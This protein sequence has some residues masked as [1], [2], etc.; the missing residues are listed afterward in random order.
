MAALAGDLQRYDTWVQMAAPFRLFEFTAGM[1]LGAMIAR[2]AAPPSPA[3]SAAPPRA[4]LARVPRVPMGTGSGPR[5]AVAAISAGI[6][7]FVGACLI[8]GGS[9]W[10]ATLQ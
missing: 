7:L 10:P 3:A 6:T 1:A 8:D 5:V 4:G 2:A 9:Q